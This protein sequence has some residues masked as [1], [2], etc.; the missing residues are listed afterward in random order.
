MNNESSQSIDNKIEDLKKLK[1]MIDSL[2]NKMVAGLEQ[3]QDENRRN[4]IQTHQ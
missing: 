3:K 1:E 4:T 2:T